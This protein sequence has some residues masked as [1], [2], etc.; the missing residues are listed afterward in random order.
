MFIRATQ[1]DFCR[2][3]DLRFDVVRHWDD[4]RM[5]EAE[6]HID[7]HSAHPFALFSGICLKRGTISNADE[8]KRD[9]KAFRHAGDGVLDES[10]GEPPH[11]A[12]FLE[13]RIFDAESEGFGSGEAEGHVR[14]EWD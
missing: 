12:L 13:L 5:A 10:A 1:D 9:G 3:W 4:D 6:L 11:G 8:V 2:V 14:F 7:P